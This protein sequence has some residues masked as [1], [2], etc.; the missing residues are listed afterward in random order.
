M[1]FC[2]A[3]M[4]PGAGAISD[5]RSLKKGVVAMQ[6]RQRSLIK[7]DITGSIWKKDKNKHVVNSLRCHNK[8]E[9]QPFLEPSI[10]LIFLPTVAVELPLL[11]FPLVLA[12][13]HLDILLLVAE[14]T[15][16]T[17]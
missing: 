1:A 11:K 14:V 15:K 4:H 5:T 2:S 6:A 13:V 7:T 16:I 9:H 10:F 17:G 8:T 12:N 3:P